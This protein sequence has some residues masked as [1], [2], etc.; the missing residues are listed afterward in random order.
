[1]S[2]KTK[3]RTIVRLVGALM[4]ETYD[5]W[6]VARRYMSLETRARV[7]CSPNVRMPAVAP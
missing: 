2:R 3:L 4:L 7:T 6:A 1:M 5:E